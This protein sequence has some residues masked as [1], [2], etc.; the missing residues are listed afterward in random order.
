V[1][2]TVV[3]LDLS[4]ACTGVAL[5]KD[6]GYETFKLKAPSVL[7][8]HERLS[9]L[10]DQILKPW[11]ADLFVV[12]GPSFGN[13]GSGERQKGHHER[14]GLWWL[15]THGL[16]A[17]HQDVAVVPPAALKRY[18]TGK[19]NAGKDDVL[20]EV[21]RRFPAFNGGNDEADALILAAMGADRLGT[22]VVTMP[23]THR[24]GLDAAQWPGTLAPKED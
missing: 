11:N 13:Q 10:L 23:A 6:G 1:V 2:S 21:V 4:L 8:S 9:W 5:A 7:R 16:W 19:G 18:A 15:V 24:T 22:P 20:R 3:G 14:A 17:E 12:E